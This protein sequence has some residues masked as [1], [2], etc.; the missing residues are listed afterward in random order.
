M[1]EELFLKNTQALF[2][3]DE[4][5]ACTLRSLKYLTFT[6]IQDENGINFKKNEILLY[7]NPNQE[8]LEN[9][10]LF[11]NKYKKYPV[12]FFYGFGNGMFY[13]TL[14]KNKQHKHII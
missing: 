7:Q 3:V 14:C 4:F 2:E 11:Q 10:T 1:R 12:L 5:L 8:F 13:K 9:L 6:L